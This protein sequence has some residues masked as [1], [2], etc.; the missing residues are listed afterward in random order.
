[1]AK[2][3]GI[4]PVS[5][6]VP[7]YNP[8]HIHGIQ[9]AITSYKINMSIDKFTM[10]TVDDLILDAIEVV[11]GRCHKRPDK[12]F[13]CKYLNVSTGTEKHTLKI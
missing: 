2:K 13:T 1:M 11:R 12:N 4:L 5:R 6:R 7:R 10:E 3:N 8:V 9:N